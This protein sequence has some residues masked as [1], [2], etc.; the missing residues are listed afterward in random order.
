MGCGT[1]LNFANLLRKH[2]EIYYVGIEPSKGSWRKAQAN[3]EGLNA[4]VINDHAY[5]LYKKLERDFEIVVSFSA[6]E[7]IYK[8]V[9]YLHSAKNCLKTDGYFLINYDSGHFLHG[10]VGEHLKSKIGPILARFG[11]ERYYQS[12]VK[13]KNFIK[14][15]KGLG[16]EIIESKFFNSHLKGIYK[17]VPQSKR[18]KYMQKWLEFEL[19]LNDLGIVYDDSKAK[20]LGTRN[21]ILRLSAGYKKE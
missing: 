19:W 5:G 18:L 8:R 20:L 13:E 11:I 4:D 15:I 21:F 1:A 10:D 6:L 3:L 7:H 9:E 2:P 17:L 16:F 12:F 14:T